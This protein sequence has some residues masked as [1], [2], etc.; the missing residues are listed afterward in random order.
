M[1]KPVAPAEKP[2]TPA[3]KPAAPA[4]KP[5]APAEKPATP[6]EK[7]ATPAE[8]PAAPA[9]KPAKPAKPN[10]DNPFGKADT[11]SLRLWT[12]MTG[13]YQITARLV[14]VLDG[15][16]RLQ[17][18]DGN[19]VRVAIDRLSVADQKFVGSLTESFATAW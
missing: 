15:V 19:Y 2:A 1:E 5:A 12:D 16:A 7:P 11:G 9:E 3:E 18:A 8:K 6:A 17:Q 14:S 13:Q 4:E 10:D